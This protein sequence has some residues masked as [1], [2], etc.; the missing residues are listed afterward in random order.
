MYVFKIIILV[1]FFNFFISIAC[2]RKSKTPTPPPEVIDTKDQEGE[3]IQQKNEEEEEEEKEEEEETPEPPPIPPTSTPE[4]FLSIPESSPKSKSKAPSPQPL[5]SEELEEEKEEKEKE[6]QKENALKFFNTKDKN[7]EEE[8]KSLDDEKTKKFNEII[9]SGRFE[10]NDLFDINKIFHKMT[11]ADSIELYDRFGTNQKNNNKLINELNKSKN[12]QKNINNL[13]I[14]YQN[15]LKKSENENENLTKY[16][17]KND[18][19]IKNLSYINKICDSNDQNTNTIIL[20]KFIEEIQPK[21][22]TWDNLNKIKLKNNEKKI[23]FVKF[24]TNLRTSN[25]EKLK[26]KDIEI[27]INQISDKKINLKDFD[28]ISTH[29]NSQERLGALG[30]S[31]QN[32]LNEIILIIKKELNNSSSKKKIIDKDFILPNIAKQ[33]NIKE[34]EN[35]IFYNNLLNNTLENQKN[36][37]NIINN[38]TKID[39]NNTKILSEFIK[40]LKPSYEFWNKIKNNK[41]NI[42]DSFTAQAK[43]KFIDEKTK[44]EFKKWYEQKGKKLAKSISSFLKEETK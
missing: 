35:D 33:L 26:Q 16:L 18:S 3:I 25:K 36:I 1:V 32:E 41:I 8:I 40:V 7:Y 10:Y 4:S 42:I 34:G 2:E 22:K 24:L 13:K 23:E 21:P 37:I 20:N 38:F 44:K 27:F 6:I 39:M 17:S 31:K 9:N 28:E 5:T 19:N 12:P 11:I 15:K 43:K 14:L 29:L 30:K